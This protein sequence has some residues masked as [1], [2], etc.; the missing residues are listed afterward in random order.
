[1]NPVPFILIFTALMIFTLN[2]EHKMRSIQKDIAI[3]KSI[4]LINEEKQQEK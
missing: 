1:M 4:V 3:I 2:M